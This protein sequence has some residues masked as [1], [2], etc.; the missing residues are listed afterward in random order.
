MNRRKER[1]RK[2]KKRK[3]KNEKSKSLC[4]CCFCCCFYRCRCYCCCWRCFCCCFCCCCCWCF[5]CFFFQG[6]THRQYISV[7]TVSLVLIVFNSPF[8]LSFLRF[9]LFYFFSYRSPSEYCI[10]SH[11]CY[12]DHYSSI[13]LETRN[14]WVSTL[15]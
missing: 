1:R 3:K 5:S 8:W 12:F 6:V 9:F 13:T 7:S 2:K 4:F 14:R 11:G 10:G 15:L